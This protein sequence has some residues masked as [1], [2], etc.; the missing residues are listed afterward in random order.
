[1]YKQYIRQ[2]LQTLKQNPLVSTISIIGTALAISFVMVIV[3]LYQIRTASYRPEV[4]RDR[5]LHV[6]NIRSQSLSNDD[7]NNSMVSYRL[8]KD[9]LYQMEMPELVAAYGDLKES[10]LSTSTQKSYSRFFV[11]PTD[12]NFWNFFEFELLDGRYYTNEEFQ[13]GLPLAVISKKIAQI[14]F[15]DVSPVGYT[16]NINLKPHRIIGVVDDVSR[17][18]S[19]AYADV[20]IPITSD[21]SSM[22]SVNEDATGPL[23]VCLLARN[24]K[25]KKVIKEEFQQ[26]IARFQDTTPSFK[27]TGRLMDSHWSALGRFWS[28][29]TFKNELIQAIVIILF[30]LLLPAINLTGITMNNIRQRFSE[31]GIRKV[32]GASKTQLVWQIMMENLVFTIIGAFIGYLLSF[33]LINWGRNFLLSPDTEL[34]VEMLFRPFGFIA[35]VIFCLVMNILSAAIPAWRMAGRPIVKSI[36]SHES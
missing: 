30:L 12:A 34:T 14:L 5:T 31:I 6:A 9:Y 36:A 29:V 35:A 26:T 22:L 13:S 17:A 15:Q 18:A 21:R 32:F 28:P 10:N 11:K 23:E 20:W 1:M 24:A 19:V 27:V 7:T 16:L 25:D 8:L 2:A 4:N 3:M 33:A